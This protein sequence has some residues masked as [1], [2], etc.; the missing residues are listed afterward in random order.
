MGHKKKFF[1][2]GKA[3]KFTG[4]NRQHSNYNGQ[5]SDMDIYSGRLQSSKSAFHS[6]RH[7]YLNPHSKRIVPRKV[8]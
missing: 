8:E 7:A 5:K 6:R 2:R 4:L 3:S 1:Q